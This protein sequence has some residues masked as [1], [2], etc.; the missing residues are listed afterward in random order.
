[1]NVLSQSLWPDKC[2]VA[3]VTMIP[4]MNDWISQDIWWKE[5]IALYCLFIYLFVLN[6]YHLPPAY[7]SHYAPAYINLRT[8]SSFVEGLYPLIVRIPSQIFPTKKIRIAIR[9]V[10]V[11][12]PR[13][14]LVVVP[15]GRW[16][17]LNRYR[18][19]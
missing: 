10:Y 15:I 5:N 18:E 4:P 6:A 13:T 8:P 12:T 16:Q 9:I 19:I 3:F 1:M 2:F 7:I 11:C 14:C 17:V